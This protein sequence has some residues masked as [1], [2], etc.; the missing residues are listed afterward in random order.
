MTPMTPMDLKGGFSWVP[1]IH[2][3]VIGAHHATNVTNGTVDFNLSFQ[4]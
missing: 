4:L 2:L 1:S 3:Q